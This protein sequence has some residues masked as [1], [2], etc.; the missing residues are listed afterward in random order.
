MLFRLYRLF[1]LVTRFFVGLIVRCFLI[2]RYLA[3]ETLILFQLQ[4]LLHETKSNHFPLLIDHRSS[5]PNNFCQTKRY[6]LQRRKFL[7]KCLSFARSGFVGGRQQYQCLHLG[8]CRHLQAE[9][10]GA[11]PLIF[12]FRWQQ[13]V[14]RFCRNRNQPQPTEY[15]SQ[16]NDPQRRHCWRRYSRQF[17]RKSYG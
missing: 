10:S 17:Y 5:S 1:L 13:F 7:G 9:H 3:S 2:I 16:S 6:R 4:L 14:R 11:K 12:T 8:G 15:R